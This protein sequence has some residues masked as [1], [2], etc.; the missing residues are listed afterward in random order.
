M[1]PGQARC[2]GESDLVFV[3]FVFFVVN[4]AATP[5]RHIEDVLGLAGLAQFTVPQLPQPTLIP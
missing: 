3:I 1:P 5:D 2:P 4:L